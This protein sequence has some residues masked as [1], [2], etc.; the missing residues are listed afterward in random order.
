MAVQFEFYKN[1]V[2][3]EEEEGEVNYHPRVVNL[4]HVTTQKLAAE[5]HTATTFGE[6]EVEAMLME[7]SRCMGKHLREGRRV[8]LDGIGYFQV[9]LQATEPIHSI[10]AHANKVKFKS[11]NFQADKDLKGE[12]IGMHAQRS[13]YKPHSASLSEA[14]IDRLLTKYFATNPVLTRTDLQSLCHFTQSM[15]ARHLRRLKE[16]GHIQNIGIRTQPIYV[17]CPGY[18]GK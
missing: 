16:Q 2:R 10:T 3:D 17:P 12:L 9:T 5:I 1:P 8:H 14:D 13:K 6:A 18:Y 7:L 11:V 4:Q 15:A